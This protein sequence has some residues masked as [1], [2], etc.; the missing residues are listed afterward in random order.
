[1]ARAALEDRGPR[2]TLVLSR[3]VEKIDSMGFV[4][5]RWTQCW[6]ASRLVAG[7]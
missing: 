5:P 3:T 7:C 2:V 6:A 4:V 1:M